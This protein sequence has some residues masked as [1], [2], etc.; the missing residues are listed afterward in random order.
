MRSRLSALVVAAIASLAIA[1]CGGEDETTTAA[2][3]SAEDDFVA[4]VTEACD[5]AGAELASSQ[6]ALQGAV[7]NGSGDLQKLVQDEL[8]PVYDNLISD[9]EAISPPEGQ[10]DTYDELLGNLRKSVDLLENK[11]ED[12]FAAAQGQTNAV[13]QQVD[14][15]EAESDQLAAELGVPQN[16]GEGETSGATGA[17]GTP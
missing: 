16:C 2:D 10:A 5:A 9:L 14:Q 1:A 15:L 4:Q 6:E 11:T 8:V 13:T 7:L 12:V 3:S 17:E